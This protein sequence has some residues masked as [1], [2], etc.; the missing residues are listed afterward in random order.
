MNF[1]KRLFGNTQTQEQPSGDKDGLYFYAQ[2]DRCSTIV[3]VRADKQHDLNREDSG[4]VW[5]KTI[6]DSKCFKPMRTVVHLDQNYRITHH[7]IEGGRY[8][9]QA[10]YEQQQNS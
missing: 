3:R 2:C 5:H 4:F 9:T 1:F 6:V 8:V 7:D 10:D